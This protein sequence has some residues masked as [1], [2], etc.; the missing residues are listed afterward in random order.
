MKLS[1][2]S[3]TAWLPFGPSVEQPRQVASAAPVQPLGNPGERHRRLG[4]HLTR[5]SDLARI[6]FPPPPDRIWIAGIVRTPS[7]LVCLDSAGLGVL[8][9]P[10]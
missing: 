2:M 9:A 1:V 8:L 10:L 7:S 4:L 6:T 3:H 5:E